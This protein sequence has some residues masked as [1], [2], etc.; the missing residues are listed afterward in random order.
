[1]PELLK[2]PSIHGHQFLKELK[3]MT[4]LY[5]IVHDQRSLNKIQWFSELK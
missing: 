3:A 1:V 2:A 4:N 5:P